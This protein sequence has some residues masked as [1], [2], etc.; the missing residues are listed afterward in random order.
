[1]KCPPFQ[2]P[3]EIEELLAQYP[4]LAACIAEAARHGFIS[5]IK[6]AADSIREARSVYE[7]K[8][9]PIEEVL[10]AQGAPI[11]AGA[12]MVALLVQE[13][14]LRAAVAEIGREQAAPA[15]VA[16]EESAFVF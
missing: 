6:A 16:P 7:P 12:S 9:A 2:L 5:G 8:A 15:R 1:M 3:Q 10:A 13:L 14:A 11:P 4:V